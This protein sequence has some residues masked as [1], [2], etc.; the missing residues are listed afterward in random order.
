MERMVIPSPEEFFGFKMGADLKL[1]RWDKIVDYF[2]LLAKNSDKIRVT[3]LGKTVEGNPFLLAII[4]SAR[5]MNNL[6]RIRKISLRLAYSG[7]LSE[8]EANSL[9]KNGKAV[10]A[11]TNSLHATEVGGTQM[12]SELAY[13]LLTSDS[14][15]IKHILDQVVLLLVPCA[16]PDGNIMVVDWYNKWL[17]TEYEGTSPPWLYQKYTGH[18]NNRDIVMLNMPESKML[19]KLLFI[20]W[21]PQAYIDHHHMGSYSARYYIPPFSNPADPTVDPLVWRTNGR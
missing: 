15:E 14:P 19:A 3:E 8:V 17:G 4:T 11:I 20:D 12:V 2:Q 16:N 5:N 21:F 13:T 7:R 18:D 10:V 1:A 9:V 6:E